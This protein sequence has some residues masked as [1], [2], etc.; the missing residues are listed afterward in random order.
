MEQQ[1]S[2]RTR[3]RKHSGAFYTPQPVVDTLVAWAVRGVTDRMLDP[4]CGDGRFLAQHA[5][6]VG[7]EQDAAAAGLAIACA[8]GAL[9]HEGEFFSWATSTNERF[10]CAAGNPPFIRYQTFKGEVRDRA[11]W[12]CTRFGVY[13]SG[14][15]SSW[16]P[17]LVAVASLLKPGGRIAFV[18]PAEIGHAPYAA[19]LLEYLVGR[20]GVVHVTAV[21]QKFFAELSEDCW[22]LYA[23]GFGHATESIR[24]STIDHFLPMRE[25]PRNYNVVGVDEWRQWNRRLR[26]FLLPLDARQIYGEAAD[27]PETLR[28]QQIADV[29]IGYVSGANDFF[30]MRPSNAVRWNIPPSLLRPSVRGGRSLPARRVTRATVERWRKEDEAAFLLHL[31]K[32]GR[33]PA[34]VMRYLDSEAGQAARMSYKCSVREPWYAVP[35]VKV[36]DYFLTY[37]SGLEA[38]LVRNDAGCVCTNSVHAMFIRD[39][40]GATR[41]NKVWDSPI[42]KLSC[43]LEGHPLG[44]GMLKLEPRE[45]G[46]IVVPS[47]RRAFERSEQVT[48]AINVAR[49]W[50]S[51]GAQA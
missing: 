5:N 12:L 6:S 30:H 10:E 35:D 21:R 13:F 51:H 33:P 50:R 8:P 19:P 44:G 23:E 14:L 34:E 42:M 15:S 28:L 36:P 49:R 1:D 17:F 29:G 18:V 48:E 27:D 41:L 9:V 31:P 24:L 45:A 7:I 46:R 11:L 2:S 40:K 26:P 32:Q 3:H 37:M 43:E 4:A 47:L 22:L 16:A 39:P 20:F 25:P 38:S